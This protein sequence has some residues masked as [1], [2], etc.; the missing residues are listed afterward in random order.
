[1]KLADRFAAT[2]IDDWT[3]KELKVKGRSLMNKCIIVLVVFLCVA[4]T[5]TAA[6][7]PSTDFARGANFS[8]YKTYKW[9]H[10]KSAQEIDELTAEQLIGTLEVALTKKGLTK[11]KSEK[12]DL[13]IGYQITD[14]KETHGS[15]YPIGSS[16][17]QVAAAESANSG[18]PP[19]M[20]HTGELTLLFFDAGNKQLV[21]RSSI[22]NAIDAEAKPEKKQKHM[23]AAIEKLLKDF[24]PAKKS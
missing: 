11:S 18:T 15:P 21:W 3:N 19:A 4:L 22:Y 6:Q 9:V 13:Y 7:G 24:P 14:A 12:A 8:Q 20:V 17:D 5:Q 1:V 23:D 2:Y 16:Y 10:I